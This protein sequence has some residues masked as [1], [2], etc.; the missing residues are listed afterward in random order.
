VLKGGSGKILPHPTII[1]FRERGGNEGGSIGGRK[2]WGGI[3]PCFREGD[4]P[5]RPG[6]ARSPGKAKPVREKFKDVNE[7]EGK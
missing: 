5:S 2:I 3:Q 1:G 4:C 6:F 7:K